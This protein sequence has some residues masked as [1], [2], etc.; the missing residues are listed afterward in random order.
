MVDGTPVNYLVANMSY[1]S[2]FNLTGNPVVVIPIGYTRDGMPIGVQIVGRRWRDMELLSIA[3]Q[4][5]K[6]AGAYRRPEGY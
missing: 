6:V 1:T 2:I 5:D 4:L 3:A